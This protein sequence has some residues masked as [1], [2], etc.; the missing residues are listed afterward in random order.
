MRVR[1]APTA[2][3]LLTVAALASTGAAPAPSV[4]DTPPGWVVDRVRFEPVDAAGGPLT[5][6][7]VGTYRGAIEIVPAPGGLAVVNEVGLQDYLKGIAEVPP[8][9]PVQA[10]RAQVIAART[11][12]LHS[13]ASTADSPWKA[14][15]AH[16][17]PTQDCQVYMG[18]EADS[19]PSS[20][21]WAA[22]VDDTAGQVLLS[23]GEPILAMYS[24]S[25]GGRSV[26]GGKPY[27][28]AV[29]DPDD[30]RSGIGRWRQVVP[31]SALAPVLNVPAELTLIG[32]ARRGA[33][34][35][36][37]VRDANGVVSEHSAGAEDFRAVANGALGA[38]AGRSAAIP[39]TDYSLQTAGG[40][41]VFE[42]RGL[43]HGIGMSQWGAR[44]KA[45]RGLSAGDILAAYYG[46]IRPTT[47]PP[48]Q[49]PATIRVAVASGRSSVT[50][51]PERYLRMVSGSGEQLGGIELG[52]WRVERAPEG[53]RVVPPEGRDE[54][55]TVR[56]AT[57]EPPVRVTEPPVVRYDLTAPA[58]VTLRY[59]TPTGQPGTVPAQVVDA[60]GAAHPLPSPGGG[61]DYRVVIEAD[62]GPGRFV[63]VPLEVQVQGPSRIASATFG[64]EGRAAAGRTG[65]IGLAVLLVTGMA[66]ATHQAA[67]RRPA[68]AP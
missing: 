49:L 52:R 38:P 64:E 51:R 47:L 48:E 27:L 40:N 1:P 39:S 22:A 10:L 44:G 56:T 46:G 17:C 31:L 29:N 67:T 4:A 66:L 18:L 25:N 32:V 54:P 30:A 37:A 35:V 34:V 20:D 12:A 14:A 7:G 5:A 58:V 62:G 9:W 11:Y 8:E 59:V 57:L 3:A 55:L 6:E 43:G 26:P 45:Q 15:G 21:R 50:V 60:G 2:F 36:F 24:A 41:A 16:I 65:M 63:A 28:R 42:G 53:V 19:R 68:A 61:G 13:M 33:N 23:G